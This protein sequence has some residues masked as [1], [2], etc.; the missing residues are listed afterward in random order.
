MAQ[1]GKARNIPDIIVFFVVVIA[2]EPELI[3]WFTAAGAFII[4]L[5]ETVDL[6]H[7]AVEQRARVKAVSPVKPTSRTPSKTSRGAVF[8]NS[9]EHKFLLWCSRATA[10]RNITENITADSDNLFKNLIKFLPSEE[11][12][13]IIGNIPGQL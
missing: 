11:Q 13:N 5:A 2:I 3:E 10:L 9:L 4:V 8:A 6:H 12:V 1:A 7:Q